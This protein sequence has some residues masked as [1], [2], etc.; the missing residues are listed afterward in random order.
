MKINKIR[1]KGFRGF[2]KEQ[3]L[4]IDSNIVLI[5]GL[6][7]AGKSSF[8][9]ALEWLFFGEI[10]R[11]RLSRCRSEYQ[12]E[13]YLKNL[14]YSD[15]ESPFVEIEG[16][17][18]EKNT[19]L[20]KEIGG[21]EEKYFINGV[22]VD[23]FSSLPLNL[24]DYFRPMLAQTEIK[25]L[26]DSEQKDRW[27]QLS[28]I[29]GQDVLTKL[30]ENLISLRN[31]KRDDDYKK[32]E[33]KWQAL[34]DDINASPSLTNIIEPLQKLDIKKLIL[35]AKDIIKSKNNKID[36][37]L[38]EIKET[39]KRLLNSELGNRVVEISYDDSTSLSVF[40]S[41]LSNCLNKLE[42]YSIKS[43]KDGLDHSY[44]EFIKVGTTLIN[45]SKCPFCLEN[46]ITQNRIDSI[47]EILEK[48]R[49][50]QEAMNQFRI[51]K[52]SI[53]KWIISFPERIKSF[54]PP[55]QSLKIISQKLSDIDEKLLASEMQTMEKETSTFAID[56][57]KEFNEAANIF[58]KY[59]ENKYFHKNET[60]EDANNLITGLT[61]KALSKQNEIISKWESLKSKITDIIPASNQLS[62]DEIK[63]WFLLEK[64]VT[65][66]SENKP[67]IKRTFLIRDVDSIQSKLEQYE[68]SEVVRLLNEH[69]IEIKSYYQRL[70]PDD[71]I[72]FA[73]IEV[74][75]GARRQ[76]K[77]KAEAFGKDIN[78]ITFFS[79]AHTN[80]LALSIYFPQRVDRN[81]TWET[82]I[83]DDPVQSM[84][85]NHSQA[86]IDILMDIGTKKKVIVLTHSKSFF[87]RLQARFYHLRP[88]IYSFFNNGENG[89]SI[90]LESGETITHIATTE[91]YCAKG[92]PH[93][94]EDASHQ[95]RKAI[96]SVCFELLLDKGITF[97]KA[98][99]LQKSGLDCL[100][101]EC[102]KMGLKPEDIGKLRS[103]LDTSNADSHAWSIN[104][105]TQGGIRSGIGYINQIVKDYL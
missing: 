21:T 30:R 39:Q 66:F 12:Y 77:L 83:L 41:E 92:D 58:F 105:T 1:I 3:T 19:V 84:D 13:E 25:A 87:K 5:Y 32:Q 28:S 62:Q 99:K 29:L 96:E 37:I 45:D 71:S 56:L 69:A 79:E 101:A 55:Q 16:S 22:K 72:Q 74:K 67:F 36:E 88:R 33:S 53:N 80:S 65:F 103:L 44:L 61:Q 81:Y 76:A 26:V 31:N 11:Q 15:T 78:P 20:R 7:G 9:E 18:N 97:N 6:N 24:E 102:E 59:V 95:L 89:P 54:L 82:V 68:K 47:N 8:T 91:E 14:F 70:N 17:I 43:T 86:L 75:G 52:E 93:S 60:N 64:V 100:F 34:M 50:T 49:E 38:K 90:L 98:R 104:D 27:E 23:S 48:N 94:L 85:E 10:S 2:N 42:E 63:K 57:A 35:E 4:L 46:T 51:I 40:L 73:G